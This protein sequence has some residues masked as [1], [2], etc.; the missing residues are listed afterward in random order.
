MALSRC[1]RNG[2]T[3]MGQV[4]RP[5]RQLH[6]VRALFC[7][8]GHAKRRPH[9]FEIA[10][11]GCRMTRQ[12]PCE[13]PPLRKRRKREAQIQAIGVTKGDDR[14][15]ADGS[16]GSIAARG[17]VAKQSAISGCRSSDLEHQ[18][19]LITL[20]PIASRDQRGRPRHGSKSKLRGN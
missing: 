18:V 14:G 3:G 6:A 20:T 11:R 9:S 1:D 16:N 2:S 10:S 12:Q 19:G 7:N 17:S 5:T 8:L 4:E 15:P 13:C